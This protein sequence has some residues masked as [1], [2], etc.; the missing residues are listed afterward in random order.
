M[1]RTAQLKDQF[2]KWQVKKNFSKQELAW[3][4]SEKIK[5]GALG[6]RA[7]FQH[8]GHEVEEER[9]ERALKRHRSQMDTPECI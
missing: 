8:H 7:R 5:R 9:L 6:K 4:A 3:M 2:R 1:T